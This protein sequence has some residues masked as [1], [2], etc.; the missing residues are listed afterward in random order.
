MFRYR[1]FCSRIVSSH[2]IRP[3]L[4][5]AALLAATAFSITSLFIMSASAAVAA[6]GDGNQALLEKL[7]KMERRIQ[8]LEAQ[9]KQQRKA[10]PAADKDARPVLASAS[11]PAKDANA[12]V[13][14]AP[15]SD[16][17]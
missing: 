8:T 4:T 16:A 17:A 1:L 9:L 14:P 11:A 10:A 5:R 12:A 2:P 13:P 15:P 3:R 7:E 6:E